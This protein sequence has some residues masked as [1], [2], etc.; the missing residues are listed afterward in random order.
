MIW[1]SKRSTCSKR[2][3][4]STT[5]RFF[6]SATI[7]PFS[8]TRSP[9]SSRRKAKDIWKE[10]AGGY[11]DWQRV[12]SKPP[13]RAVVRAAAPAKTKEKP[14]PPPVASGEKLSFKEQREL[15]ALP[16]RIS[17]LE[18]EERAL[19]ARLA[20]PALYQ[21]APDTVAEI[22]ARLGVVGGK[23]AEAMQRWEELESRGEA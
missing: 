22:T 12:R 21:S 10:Y 14:K 17:A 23:M 18:A 15:D 3:L 20:D 4:P 5:V 19:Q 6:W 1:T 8:T 9:R 13:A 11:A 7:A 2:C 16:D